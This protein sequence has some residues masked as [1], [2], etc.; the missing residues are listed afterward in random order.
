M[1]KQYSIDGAS[2]SGRARHS[3]Q[4][5]KLS[6]GIT[7]DL[8]PAQKMEK[9]HELFDRLVGCS[10][11]ISDNLQPGELQHRLEGSANLG[12]MKLLLD[13][14]A[15]AV[16]VL[17]DCVDEMRACIGSRSEAGAQILRECDA[18]YDQ[19][20][21]RFRLGRKEL[22]SVLQDSDTSARRLAPSMKCM[23]VQAMS[24]CLVLED[25]IAA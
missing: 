10:Q 3:F 13:E 9:L 1:A 4:D 22:T 5:F 18:R 24:I 6:F 12:D 2:A 16:R 19:E 7:D 20:T 25:M 15:H 8:P 17:K 21:R 14:N 11:A 23:A